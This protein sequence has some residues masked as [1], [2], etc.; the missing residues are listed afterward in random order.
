MRA[1]LED[2]L[3]RRLRH[4]SPSFGIVNYALNGTYV[5]ANDGPTYHFLNPG[6]SDRTVFLPELEQLGGQ[7]YIIANTG[8]LQLLNVVDSN[9]VAVVT[10]GPNETALFASSP[11]LWRYLMG[12]S[13]GAAYVSG[14][15]REPRVTALASDTVGSTDVTIA[16]VKAAPTATGIQLPTVASRNGIPVRIVDWSTAVVEHTITITPAGA[17]TIMRQA[18]WP[19]VSNTVS[20]AS[21]T[22]YPSTTLGGWMVLP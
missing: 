18:T 12:S 8:S 16:I 7:H 19:I 13:T 15:L 17:E 6:A 10:I 21:I 14:M 5:I 2:N 1:N 20:L 4:N 9:G 11:F 3:A 22:L